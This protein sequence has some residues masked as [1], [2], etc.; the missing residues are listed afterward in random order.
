MLKLIMLCL[1][2]FSLAA[3]QASGDA[4]PT[5]VSLSDFNVTETQQAAEI[6]AEQTATAPTATPTRVGPPTLPPTFTPTPETADSAAEAES[7]DI[8]PSAPEVAYGGSQIYY[9]Y[10]GDSVALAIS[11]D[12]FNDIVITFGVGQ[13][14]RDLRPSP[15][16]RQ[17]AFVAP[18]PGSARDVYI[19]A[20]NGD[21]IQRISCLG[22]SDVRHPVWSPDGQ[23]LAFYGAPT[24]LAPGAIYVAQ[25]EGSAQCPAGNNQRLLVDLGASE[26]RGM[27]FNRDGSVLF[28]AGG[29]PSIR[30]VDIASG[31]VVIAT[32]VSGF[33]PDSRPVQNPVNDRIMYIRPTRLTDGTTG[34]G[35]AFID[36]SS[37][38]PNEPFSSGVSPY[39]ALDLRWAPDGQQFMMMTQ[40]NVLFTEGNNTSVRPV[41]STPLQQP[42]A[43]YSPDG[44]ALAFTQLDEAGVLNVFVYDRAVRQM[45]RITQNEE[46]SIADLWWLPDLP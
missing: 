20:R 4:L 28:F 22:F 18:G 38:L 30:A 2:L 40:D 33:G 36:D 45:T 13:P 19:S 24:E 11:G 26:M 12:G 42:A 21:Q 35:L 32:Y 29:D 9:I 34:G 27:T 41:S 10:N 8:A 6:F 46:G 43:A 44:R 39:N 23:S 1:L 5:L 14:I 17:F 31:N 15:D 3:C 37:Q 16:S 7:A 25:V